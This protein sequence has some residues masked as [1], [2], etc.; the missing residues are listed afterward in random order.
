MYRNEDLKNQAK[1][2]GAKNNMIQDPGTK[3]IKVCFAT[4][5]KSSEELAIGQRRQNQTRDSTTIH[6]SYES[7]VAICV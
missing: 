7:Q 6:R 1:K 4:R 2:S 5:K 3:C